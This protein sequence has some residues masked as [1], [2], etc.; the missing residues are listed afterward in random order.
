[1]IDIKELEIGNIVLKENPNHGNLEELCRVFNIR[2]S[3]ASLE[4]LGKYINSKGLFKK[5]PKIEQN[6]ALIIIQNPVD[7]HLLKPVNITQDILIRCGFR[8]TEDDYTF[9]KNIQPNIY[10][11][12]LYCHESK[13]FS[14]E[15]VD[16]NVNDVKKKHSEW[17]NGLHKLQNIY[18]EFTKIE[19]N[20]N[21]Q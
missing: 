7:F 2:D 13:G 6:N 10:D 15:L 12:N 14:V 16:Y 18:Y 11:V 5:F 17:F 4:R 9:I 3:V 20:I 19:L 1:M 8:S 21:L